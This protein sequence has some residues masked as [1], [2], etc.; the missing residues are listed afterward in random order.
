[1]TYKYRNRQFNVQKNFMHSVLNMTEKAIKL[2]YKELNILQTQWCL[3]TFTF[4]N[5]GNIF[6]K[7]SSSNCNNSEISL[8]S[9]GGASG[10]KAPASNLA[11]PARNLQNIKNKQAD[12]P[13]KKQGHPMTP[14]CCLSWISVVGPQLIFKNVCMCK[15]FCTML[16]RRH[17]VIKVLILWSWQRHFLC[18]CIHNVY[19]Q[20]N[21]ALHP[22]INLCTYIHPH[23]KPLHPLCSQFGYT[24]QENYLLKMDV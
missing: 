7:F 10:Y 21:S 8:T 12:Q 20:Y 4:Y 2:A 9:Q 13:V 6:N 24:F 23:W 1:M 16:Y 3:I 18:L 14:T 17:Y 11:A 22:Y 15:M 5:S 19:T